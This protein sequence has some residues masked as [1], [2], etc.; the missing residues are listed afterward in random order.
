MVR[1]AGLYALQWF[2]KLDSLKTEKK[3]PQDLVSKADREVEK[4]I[5]E[6]LQTLFPEDG[7][8]GEES[9]TRNLDA[10]GIWIVDPIDGTICFLNG[11]SSWC[12]SIAFVVKNQIEIG[13]I[14]APCMDE[15]FAAQLGA[16]ATLNGKPMKPS[17]ATSLADGIVGLGYSPKS[18]IVATQK[19]FD[20]LFKNGGVYHDV[21]SAALMLAYVAAGRYIGVYEFQIN[22]WDCLAGIAMV[23]E[24]GGWTNDFLANDGL[25]TGNPVLVAAPGVK[26]A[27]QK[28]FAAAGH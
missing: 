24:T 26:D 20:Y 1:D 27:M 14:Y 12:V 3:G 19:A 21:G 17:K 5:R 28:L 13:L 10:E 7:F 18:S 23:R 16:G 4:M 8:L 22:S 25:L 9:G 2:R 15:L 6:R 11:L